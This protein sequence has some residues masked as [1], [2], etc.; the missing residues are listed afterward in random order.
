[1]SKTLQSGLTI[2][3]AANIGT[4]AEYSNGTCTTTVTIPASPNRQN[5][6]LTNGDACAITFTQPSSGT[7]SITL[8]LIQGS[9]GTGTLGTVATTLWAQSDGSFTDTPPTITTTNNAVSLLGCYLDG[10]DAYC[11]LI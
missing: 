8:K 7:T 4:A 9:A 2:P 5:V 3:A 6:T 11:G 10:T 1:M